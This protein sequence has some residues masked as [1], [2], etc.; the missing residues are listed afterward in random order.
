[1]SER[2]E[3]GEEVTTTDDAPPVNNAPE[4]KIEKPKSVSIPPS[5]AAAARAQSASIAATVSNSCDQAVLVYFSL[6][7]YA[8]STWL[9]IG[10]ML[11]GAVCAAASGVP[12]PLMAILFGELVNDLNGAACEADAR[13]NAYSYEDAVDDKVLQ[14]VYIAVAAMVLIFIYVVCWSL[15]SQRLAHRLRE[16][17]FASLLRQDQAFIDQHQAGEVSSRLN[18]DIQTVQSGTCEKV[19]IFIASISFFIAS[20]VVAFIKEARLAG[21]LISLI[22][23]FLL[24]AIIGGAFFQKYS[25]RMSDAATSASSIASEALSHIAVVKAFSAAPRLEQKFSEYMTVSRSHGIRKGAVAASQAGFLYFIGYSANA[26]AFW[27]GSHMI[28][29]T[30]RGKGNGSTI[31]EIYTVVFILVDG[32]SGSPLVLY[33]NGADIEC[34]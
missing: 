11:V 22:P 29:D 27:Q 3:S 5:A 4:Q 10:L 31:G 17:Y 33:D 16:Q 7:K 9:D 15:L 25:S 21:M 32:T 24:V 12:F 18:G 20:Y 23:A 6:L 2:P 19:G 28:A 1:M 13:G 14:L 30:L 26:L 34:Y 8:G